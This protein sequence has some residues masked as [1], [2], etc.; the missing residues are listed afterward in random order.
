MSDYEAFRRLVVDDPYAINL[1]EG[2]VD[3]PHTM[4]V[5]ADYLEETDGSETDRI[6]LLRLVHWLTRDV[7]QPDRE[8]KESRLR[9]L[10]VQGVKPIRYR[11]FKFLE[12]AVLLPLVYIPP[13][14]FLMGS[15]T[16]R[17][18]RERLQDPKEM[19]TG[20]WFPDE[21]PQHLEVVDKGFYMGAYPITQLQW[22]TVMGSNPSVHVDDVYPVNRV[23]W[24]DCNLFCKKLTKKFGNKFRLPTEIEWEYACR[25]GTTTDF[26]V[27]N[28]SCDRVAWYLDNV[29]RPIDVKPVTLLLPNAFGLFDMHGNVWEWCSN[30]FYYYDNSYAAYMRDHVCRGGS[31]GSTANVCRSAYRARY[32]PDLVWYNVG[33]RVVMDV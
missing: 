12:Y 5:L 6:E 16:V 26:Y 32:R 4:L 23:N 31:V 22:R 14:K 9:E 19:A 33:M 21:K 2:I 25:A 27:D 28:D 24:H 10:I 18:T 8:V 1:L 30:Q 11:I 17:L 3:D 13:G 20:L 7:N 29:E 15:D